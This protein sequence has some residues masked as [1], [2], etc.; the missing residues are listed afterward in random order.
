MGCAP[1]KPPDPEGQ[2][3]EVILRADVEY[4]LGQLYLRYAIMPVRE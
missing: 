2:V 1:S 4:L 3:E